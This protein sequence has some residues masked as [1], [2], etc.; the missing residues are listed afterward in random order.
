LTSPGS[1]L[2]VRE[3]H[4]ISVEIADT[5]YNLAAREGRYC[6]A[7]R[8]NDSLLKAKRVVLKG[9]HL[10]TVNAGGRCEQQTT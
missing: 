5:N 6:F 2:E 8:I 1:V 10:C 4:G 7:Q 3:V 9:A